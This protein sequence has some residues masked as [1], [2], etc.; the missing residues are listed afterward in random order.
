MS[1]STYK[2]L[3]TV[4]DSTSDS[5]VSSPNTGVG[6]DIVANFKNIADIIHPD[7][8]SATGSSQA[9][10]VG[11]NFN[12]DSSSGKSFHILNNTASFVY[13]EALAN[14]ISFSDATGFGINSGAFMKGLLVNPSTESQQVKLIDV[15]YAGGMIVHVD[16]IAVQSNT[17]YCCNG[18]VTVYPSGVTANGFASELGSFSVSNG[19]LLFVFDSTVQYALSA[20]QFGLHGTIL[21]GYVSEINSFQSSQGMLG[22]SS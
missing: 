21:A 20:V 10:N 1:K 15:P 8:V 7:N 17:I 5:I 16:I 19:D 6:G 22:S 13:T 4:P 3:V 9:L 2:N 18:T 12:Y 14:S 11:C